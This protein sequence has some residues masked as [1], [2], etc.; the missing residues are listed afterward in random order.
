ME[1]ILFWQLLILEEYTEEF[2][3]EEHSDLESDQNSESCS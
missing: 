1:S 3:E 2:K